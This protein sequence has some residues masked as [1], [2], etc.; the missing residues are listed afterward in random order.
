MAWQI[1]PADS[2][3]NCRRSALVS[4]GGVKTAL[5]LFFRFNPIG[6]YWTLDIARAET[7]ETLLTGVPL[8][9]GEGTAFDIL[10]QFS[11]LAL[12][13]AAVVPASD[14]LET[15]RP[16]ETNLGTDFVLC[17]EG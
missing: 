14:A 6:G 16:L 5:S 2:A 17:W 13:R 10:R 3:A 7:D 8:V 1:V 9:C 4:V 11:H 15:G 12:G